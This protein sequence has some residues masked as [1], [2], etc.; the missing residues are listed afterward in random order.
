MRARTLTRWLSILLCGGAVTPGMALGQTEPPVE[1][2]QPVLLSAAPQEKP[3]AP[4]V[5]S[6]APKTLLPASP[7][8]VAP[9]PIV[10][11]PGK[12]N[13]LVPLMP[14]QVMGT[15]CCPVT[16]GG[17]P[18]LS[19]SATS[20]L[21]TAIIASHVRLRFEGRFNNPRPDRSAYI[22]AKTQETP[23]PTGL[24]IPVPQGTGLPFSERRIDMETFSLYGE[25]ACSS[26]CSVFAELPLRALQPDINDGHVG[27]GDI[28]LGGK[29]ALFALPDLVQTVQC[30]V[31]CPSGD[32]HEGMG[33]D[34]FAL[35]P[36][37][38]VFNRLTPRWTLEGEI[39]D[40]IPIGNPEFAGSVLRYGLS[41]A[42]DLGS[43]AGGWQIRPV[44]GLW[45]VAFLGGRQT[46]ITPT[47]PI[48]EDARERILNAD[49]GVRVDAAES[50]LYLGYSQVLTGSA[51]F[52]HE[53]RLEWRYSF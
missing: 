7:G 35:E 8:V 46:I 30:R 53:V 4:A 39:R 36:A 24:F 42:Y 28:S 10:L 25:Y 34:L 38:L 13:G 40:W 19:E 5:E 31:Y 6:T 48:L 12:P 47:G 49:L 17:M 1:Q 21:D 2:P 29:L 32:A 44:A 41:A 9:T 26:R 51:L 43:T 50:S 52:E 27:L 33:S 23:Q 20:F 22:M 11:P 45:G 37:Y 16:H 18:P 14:G 3:A 15:N